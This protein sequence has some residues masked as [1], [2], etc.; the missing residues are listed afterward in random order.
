ML[1]N[2]TV[3]T[4]IMGKGYKLRE[5]DKVCDGWNY[6]CYTDQDNI[7]SDVW[8]IIR[9]NKIVDQSQN[10]AI[11]RV[12]KICGIDSDIHIYIDAKFKPINN[13]DGF[14]KKHLD[15]FDIVFM[16]HPKRNCVYVEADFLVKSGI[17][18]KENI[19]E[20]IEKYLEEGMPKNFGLF[21][22]GIMI[23]RNNKHVQQFSNF[24]REEYFGGTNRDMISLAYTIW[25]FPWVKV[26]VIPFRKTYKMWR[27]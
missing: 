20:Q 11:S 26:G 16:G 24:W 9:A 18:K 19:T 22:P 1:L 14:V 7:K 5:P 2:K 21:S 6:I 4:V 3:Y 8:E 27:G 17:E 15:Y 12:P 10:R 13:M 25:K 23:R